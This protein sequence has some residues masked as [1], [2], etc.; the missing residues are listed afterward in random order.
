MFEYEL[1]DVLQQERDAKDA[2]IT[3][4]TTDVNGR[5]KYKYPPKSAEAR[6]KKEIHDEITKTFENFWN[7]CI[8]S[9]EDY[10]SRI[11]EPRFSSTHYASIDIDGDDSDVHS[12]E[13]SNFSIPFITSLDELKSA[14]KDVQIEYL[15]GSDNKDECDQL[16][17]E[18]VSKI[19]TAEPKQRKIKY[20]PFHLDLLPKALNLQ[21]ENV[22]ELLPYLLTAYIFNSQQS[23]FFHQQKNDTATDQDFVRRFFIIFSDCAIDATEAGKIRAMVKTV[24]N[25]FSL[26]GCERLI[27]RNYYIDDY[28]AQLYSVR[29]MPGTTGVSDFKYRYLLNDVFLQWRYILKKYSKKLENKNVIGTI[30]YQKSRELYNHYTDQKNSYIW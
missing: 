29:M 11:D 5:V 15:T 30:D 17:K 6:V 13:Y 7:A 20:K 19:C 16:F 26:S 22:C 10:I 23:H 2:I 28:K 18:L 8:D 4:I 9:F 12:E 14:Y 25:L 24:S 1:D 27:K 21:D 3:F